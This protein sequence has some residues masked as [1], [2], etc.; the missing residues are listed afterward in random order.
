[1][2]QARERRWSLVSW[3]PP[4]WTTIVLPRGPASAATDLH[5]R[6]S[7]VRPWLIAL[8]SLGAATAVALLVG[9]PVAELRW[10]DVGVVAAILAVIVLALATAIVGRVARGRLGLARGP[11]WAALSPFS[12]PYAGE[13]LLEHA[14][15]GLDPDVVARALLS[16]ERFHAWVRP[17]VFDRDA[18]A[19]AMLDPDEGA[20]ILAPPAVPPGDPADRYCPRC[21]A[22]YR[23]VEMCADCAGIPLRPRA[24]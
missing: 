9:I 1:V 12:A 5:H 3:L 11:A 13:R 10:T 4:V 21:G 18:A 23:G 22:L 7:A 16:R 15:A 6:L 8:Q 19:L 24:T 2:D 20:M 17:R 14:L